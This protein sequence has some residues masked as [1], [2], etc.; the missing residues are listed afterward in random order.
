M[1]RAGG[2]AAND[3][4][5]ALCELTDAFGQPHR[6]GGLGMRKLGGKLFECRGTLALRFVFQDRGSE[7][8]VSFLGAHDEVK[9]LPRIVPI[10]LRTTPASKQEHRRTEPGR[11]YAPA[12]PLLLEESCH[13]A[14]YRLILARENSAR[15]IS[16]D[17]EK[18][19]GAEA[20]SASA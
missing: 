20:V 15:F 18:P 9:A 7:L 14:R 12:V 17:L 4:L 8:Y 3:C 19:V 16:R 11:A 13:G 2:G 1:Q 5:L 10:A 6:H